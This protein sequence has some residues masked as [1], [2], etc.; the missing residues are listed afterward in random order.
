MGVLKLPYA[1]S[2][3]DGQV[4]SQSSFLPPFWKEGVADD[5]KI[6]I[7]SGGQ[8]HEILE[9]DSLPIVRT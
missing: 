7:F 3:V 1:L 5:D 9:N 4:A 8:M 6:S 2:D